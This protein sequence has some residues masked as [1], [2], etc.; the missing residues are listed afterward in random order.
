[1]PATYEPIATTTLGSAAATITFNSIG[2]GYTDLRLVIV[3]TTS[4]TDTIYLQYNG[5]ST[6]TYSGTYIYGDG[7]T[8]SSARRTNVTGVY[9]GFGVVTS[10]TIPSMWTWD[11]FS[12]AGSTNK[13]SLST[14]SLDQNGSG[15]VTRSVGLWRSTSAITSITANVSGS[16]FNTGTTATLYG[17]LKA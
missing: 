4:A 17:I 5:I 16:N 3:T 15:S 10:T 12:Y 6:S 13:T 9:A 8:A 11:I 14:I 7:A 1:M 2:S